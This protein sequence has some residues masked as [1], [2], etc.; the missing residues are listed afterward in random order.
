MNV[1]SVVTKHQREETMDRWIALKYDHQLV[2][3]KEPCGVHNLRWSYS[4]SV[5]VF[6]DLDH[7]L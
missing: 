5:K 4:V 7:T 2:C 1:F 6:G 3:I